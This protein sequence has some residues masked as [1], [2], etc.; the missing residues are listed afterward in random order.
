MTRVRHT[1]ETISEKYLLQFEISCMKL[2]HTMC[3]RENNNGWSKRAYK[4]ACEPYQC[5]SW[6]RLIYGDQHSPQGWDLVNVI[7]VFRS[8]KIALF[9]VSN[10]NSTRKRTKN[11]NSE[12][13]W[14]A[15]IEGSNRSKGREIELINK[16]V[17]RKRKEKMFSTR[18]WLIHNVEVI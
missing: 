4:W 8:E 17:W 9:M 15:E 6:C 5:F 2:W 10:S 14:K 13:R 1:E 18:K 12:T 7:N 16:S 3:F 11:S